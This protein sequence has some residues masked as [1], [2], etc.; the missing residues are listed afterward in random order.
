MVLSMLN[1]LS[2]HTDNDASC[3]MCR[4]NFKSSDDITLV[5]TENYE[6]TIQEKKNNCQEEMKIKIKDIITIAKHTSKNKIL[7]KICQLILQENKHAKILIMGDYY[8]SLNLH[9]IYR[10]TNMDKKQYELQNLFKKHKMRL[11]IVDILQKKNKKREAFENFEKSDFC[12]AI[13]TT[14]YKYLIGKDLSY[15]TD[16]IFM[17]NDRT[18]DVYY[19]CLNTLKDSYSTKKH[20]AWMLRDFEDFDYQYLDLS[21]SLFNQ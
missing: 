8:K 6:K 4:Y 9:H 2:S 7:I 11:E 16:I 14:N 17:D 19:P 3:P 12:N 20:K 10:N 13:I 21:N 5:K 1:G 15:I 18:D